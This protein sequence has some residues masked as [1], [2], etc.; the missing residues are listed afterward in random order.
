VQKD[1]I[2][3][4]LYENHTTRKIK[5]ETKE[6]RKEERKTR[7]RIKKHVLCKDIGKRKEAMIFVTLGVS[8]PYRT[9]LPK[10]VT[11]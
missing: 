11:R 9:T 7:E 1:C 6:T 3:W 5:E 4:L 10:T 8:S 2:K